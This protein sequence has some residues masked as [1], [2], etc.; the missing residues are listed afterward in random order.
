MYLRRTERMSHTLPPLRFA[1]IVNSLLPS[2]VIKRIRS[3]TKLK[4]FLARK[5]DL[6]LT[7]FLNLSS[8]TTFNKPLIT[9]FLWVFSL[10]LKLSTLQG[11][12]WSH[13][14][15]GN[16]TGFEPMTLK[17]TRP[18]IGMTVEVP[19]FCVSR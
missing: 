16:E 18:L 5:Q 9:Q 15:C 2:L 1:A 19:C 3:T 4:P 8:S 14:A 11:Y 12:F 7:F 10:D 13:Q 6:F 17:R